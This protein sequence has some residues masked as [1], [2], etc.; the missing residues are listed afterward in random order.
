LAP[1]RITS[2]VLLT[3]QKK[4]RWLLYRPPDWTQKILHVAQRIYE[5]KQHLLPHFN[6]LLMTEQENAY[7]ALQTEPFSTIEL[8]F[9]LKFGLSCASVS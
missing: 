7:C 5:Y 6:W 9:V 4:K 8:F 2:Q 1:N 3:L